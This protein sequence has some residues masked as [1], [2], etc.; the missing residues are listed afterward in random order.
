MRPRIGIPC[1][2]VRDREWWP[3]LH[4]HRQSYLEAVVS[5][6]GFPLLIPLIEQEDLLHDFYGQIDGLL[7]AGGKDIDPA[8]YGEKPHDQ[9]DEVD[10]LQDRVEC[11]LTRRAVADGKP[12]L[13]ICRG[14]QMVNVALGGTLY[15]DIPSQFPTTI[16]HDASS[17]HAM[18]VNIED[19]TSRT[20]EMHLEPESQLA[21]V[22]E[23]T[24]L[25]VN[26]LHHQAI[27]R[28]APGLRVVGLSPDQVIEAVEGT[29]R[30]FLIGVQCHPEALY[31]GADSRWQ[32]LFAAFIESCMTWGI[33]QG[34]EGG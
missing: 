25:P 12:V 34:E 14:L 19:W 11:Y 29:G 4:G 10:P 1:E 13:A 27:R 8:H 2:T 16:D 20:H 31:N 5:A 17:K 15:Q 3:P 9:L 7:L 6:G 23:T 24:S 22:L 28:L 21:Y 33:E 18:A 30:S 26:S 32:A